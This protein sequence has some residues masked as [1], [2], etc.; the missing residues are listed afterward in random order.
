MANERTVI[1]VPVDF[2]PASNTALNAALELSAPLSATI[3]ALHVQDSLYAGPTE[4]PVSLA[5]REAGDDRR[6]FHES[7]LMDL[8]GRFA[9]IEPLLRNGSP[10]T[11]IVRAIRELMPA[12]V[13]MGTHGRTG[14]SRLMLGSVAEYVITRSPVPVMTIRTAS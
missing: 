13:I 3:V 7:R 2:Q 11:E 9:G 12:L 14:L 1:L 4:L 8:C 10:E 6:S 5:E